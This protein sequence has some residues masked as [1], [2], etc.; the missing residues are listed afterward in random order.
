LAPGAGRGSAV[1]GERFK[2]QVFAGFS[3]LRRPQFPGR[4]L[5][6]LFKKSRSRQ[7]KKRG[8]VFSFFFCRHL[9]VA[10]QGGHMV[11]GRGQGGA[12]TWGRA[13]GEGREQSRFDIAGGGATFSI[14]PPSVLL[15]GSACVR[16]AG[17]VFLGPTFGQRGQGA[18][19]GIIPCGGKK[20]RRAGMPGKGNNNS[21]RLGGFSRPESKPSS[22]PR[23]IAGNF[24]PATG[25]QLS[26]LNG[27]GVPKTLSNCKGGE[28]PALGEDGGKGEFLLATQTIGSAFAFFPPGAPKLKGGQGGLTPV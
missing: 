10:P 27:S 2:K 9:G 13:S 20:A 16:R 8:S 6:V 22:W 21:G 25:P 23:G 28:R 1:S 11:A 4:G 26:L 14:H 24:T 5:V 3:F 17:F 15:N 7:A 19:W 18:R 12:K